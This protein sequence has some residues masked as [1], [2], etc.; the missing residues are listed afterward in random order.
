MQYCMIV[1]STV[2]FWFIRN[3]SRKRCDATI[4]NFRPYFSSTS[5]KLIGSSS[6]RGIGVRVSYSSHDPQ[7]SVLVATAATTT[8]TT[9]AVVLTHTVRLL[10]AVKS[11]PTKVTT[12]QIV[13]VT[14]AAAAHVAP[15]ATNVLAKVTPVHPTA[16]VVAIATHVAARVVRAAT[17][18]AI[19]GVVEVVTLAT[20]AATAEPIAQAI[21]AGQGRV[22]TGERIATVLAT[23]GQAFAEILARDERQP[24]QILEHLRVA[25]VVAGV[26]V[27]LVT[28]PLHAEVCAKMRL[29]LSGGGPL[30]PRSDETF[31]STAGFL[32]MISC[33]ASEIFSS[34]SL[35][36]F[37]L[38]LP[39]T[40]STLHRT[41]RCFSSS[42]ST[43]SA[44]SLSRNSM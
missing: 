6:S 28:R 9:L 22:A 35:K 12:A 1:S 17:I 29:R 31:S 27:E 3:D 24:E 43:F 33:I 36:I 7:S 4:A 40:G 39:V 30:D 15:A 37:L 44:I 19:V 13:A 26:R 18:A 41:G 10:R 11:L 34:F 5:W 25:E 16:H 20:T 42:F 14:S 32:S 8:T 2:Q 21:Q 38:I 23:A